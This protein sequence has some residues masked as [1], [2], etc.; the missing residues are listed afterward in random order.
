MT[1]AGQMS[2]FGFKFLDKFS[3]PADVPL[4]T[5]IFEA[6]YKTSPGTV[7]SSVSMDG[8]EP[9]FQYR[10]NITDTVT[11]KITVGGVIIWQLDVIV[12]PGLFSSSFC[13]NI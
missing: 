12:V 10:A 9:V 1:T 2:V 6:N 11:L 13:H 5:I 3:N 8:T 4:S 7:D